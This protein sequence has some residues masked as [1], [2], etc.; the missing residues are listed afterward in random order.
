MRF[1][2]RAVAA[3]SG[4]A[5]FAATA[6]AQGPS[7]S[8]EVRFGGRQLF[9]DR[10][11]SKFA[12]YQ[13][14]PDG[15]FLDRVDLRLDWGQTGHYLA[16]RASDALEG[17]QQVRLRAGRAGRW[18]L[19]LEFSKLPHAY[20]NTGRTLYTETAP[21][22]FRLPDDVQAQ[23]RTIST[24]D[25][26]P[27]RSG[28]QPDLAKL[29]ALVDGLAR[30][31]G[32]SSLREQFAASFRYS[33][34][35][36]WDLRV[37]YSQENQRGRRP[38]GATFSFNATEQAEPLDYKTQQL[39]A[40][41][42]WSANAWTV[43]LGYTGA[44]LRN[45]V[46]VLLWDNPFRETDAA[47]ASAAGRIDLYPDNTTHQGTLSAAV[48]LP[49]R[50]RWTATAAYGVTL[51]DDSLLPF[52]TNSAVANVPV[53][54]AATANGEMRTFVLGST[55]T[56]R[57][58]RDLSLTFRYRLY[59]RDNRTPS[60]LFS[61]YVR[62]DQVLGG[63]A[64]RNLPIAYSRQTAGVEA[65][66]QILRPISLRGGYEWEDWDREHRDVLS[67]TEHTYSGAVD[68]TQG[69]W[70]LLRAAFRRSDRTAHDYE[71][72]RVAEETFPEGEPGLGQLEG[73]RKFDLA[74]RERDRAELIARVGAWDNLSVSASYTLTD[75]LY[76]ESEYG[77]LTNRA[78]GPALELTYSPFSRL[79]LFAEYARE[80]NRLSMRSRQRT[81]ASST[82]PANDKP[83]NDWVSDVRDLVN[84]Y[85]AG[86]SG[87]LLA[88]RL[89]IDLS[90]S[91]SDGNGRTGTRTPG[92]PDLV[93]TAVDYPAIVS[94]LRL[95]CATVSYSFSQRVGLRFDYRYEK[96][97]QIDFALDPMTPFMGN[98]DA[99]SALTTWLGATR[100]DYRAHLASLSLT[101]RL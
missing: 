42:Q 36:R 64:R 50:S 1:V 32:L 68:V 17:D 23:L 35:P 94:D 39:Q 79:S 27:T 87:E 75:D 49:L 72:H 4:L 73:L 15:W 82:T 76:G 70:L 11:S 86:L 74:S 16:L 6:R 97:D 54:P 67:T 62:T 91:V 100:P 34:A 5:L 93:T 61:N 41:L 10:A 90:Y 99:G 43:Q 19:G 37:R 13:S 28:V 101:Y 65:S 83:D 58:V 59:D 30:P 24:T 8:G 71:A 12:E 22:V 20:S 9:G 95:V 38:V 96:Y 52:T 46:D 51:Q 45:R 40:S 77:L 3:L 47:G 29:Q 81:P 26:D 25:T 88:D 80:E 85:A 2:I 92:Q 53:V 21:G 48:N 98:V 63:A 55:L 56:T 89:G 57:P 78:G 7:P 33:P 14:I 18:E 69:G 31:L 84:T 66:W 60:L 44:I